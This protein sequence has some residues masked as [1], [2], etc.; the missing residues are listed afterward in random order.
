MTVMT[1]MTVMT[2]KHG[3]SVESVAPLLLPAPVKGVAAGRFAEGTNGL[4]RLHEE[5]SGGQDWGI[6]P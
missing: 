4:K 6:G 3:K 5:G 1:V 2:G